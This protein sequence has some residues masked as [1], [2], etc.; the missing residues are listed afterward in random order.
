MIIDK[1]TNR[2]K[3]DLKVFQEVLN[4]RNVVTEKIKTKPKELQR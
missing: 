1:W 3:W 4:E 2:E